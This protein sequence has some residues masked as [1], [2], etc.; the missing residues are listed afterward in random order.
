M[1][2]NIAILGGGNLG[3]ALAKGLARTEEAQ[4]QYNV[5]VTRRNIQLIT[6]LREE[7]LAITSDN[8]EAVKNVEILILAVQPTQ[9]KALI[10]EIQP[11]LDS[12]KHILIST[13]T[14]LKKKRLAN[15]PGM[16]SL[17]F[18]SCPILQ[19]Q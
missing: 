9:V 2:T 17:L 6:H 11:A 7:G 10:E 12:Q 4:Q 3:S 18:A 8:L 15:S 16:T 1:K 5:T 19:L 14:G 13:I